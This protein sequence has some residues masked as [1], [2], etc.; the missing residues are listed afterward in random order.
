MFDI[1]ERF[2]DA[3]IEPR[4]DAV[5]L[6]KLMTDN[7]SGSQLDLVMHGDG[8]PFAPGHVKPHQYDSASRQL[9]KKHS[10][11]FLE[12]EKNGLNNRNVISFNLNSNPMD[13]EENDDR[14]AETST[15]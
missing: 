6:E 4:A 10:E 11:M 12:S 9:D 2:G 13:E 7:L 1:L 5:Q 3:S 8:D 14:T 15:L